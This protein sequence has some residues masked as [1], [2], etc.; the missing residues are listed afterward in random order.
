MPAIR[1]N[2]RFAAWFAVSMLLLL[3]GCASYGVIN[4]A[5]LT[6][7]TATDSYSI[8]NRANMQGSG[9]IVLTLAFSGG[10]TRP[11]PWPTGFWMSCATPR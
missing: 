2:R 1:A 11:L 6:E 3:S 10:G 5:P 4:N 8:V 9:D 7:S